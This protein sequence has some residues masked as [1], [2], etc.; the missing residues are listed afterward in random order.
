VARTTG[1]IT[2]STKASD[3]DMWMVTAECLV[4]KITNDTYTQKG[5]RV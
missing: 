2:K 3:V 5:T 1:V 4:V